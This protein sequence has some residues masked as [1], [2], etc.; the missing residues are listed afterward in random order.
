MVVGHHLVDK[1]IGKG[2]IDLP[3][4]HHAHVLIESVGKNLDHIE[5]GLLPQI[6]H[7]PVVAL[8]GYRVGELRQVGIRQAIGGRRSKGDLFPLA[9]IDN[10]GRFIARTAAG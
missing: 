6:G 10:T 1:R 2:D 4:P 5:A 8:E 9:E 7:Q 3:L